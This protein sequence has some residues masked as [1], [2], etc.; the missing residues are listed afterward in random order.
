M[1]SFIPMLFRQRSDTDVSFP[2]V[3]CF[4][5]PQKKS[6]TCLVSAEES[7]FYSVVSVCWGER[8]CVEE[9]GFGSV[10]QQRATGPPSEHPRGA[11]ANWELPRRTLGTTRGGR[12]RAG[13]PAGTSLRRRIFALRGHHPVAAVGPG[14]AIG[15]GEG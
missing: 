13:A 4:K 15:A 14:R 11:T 5:P 9:P 2:I 3:K 10:M 12:G 6:F 7:W 1:D 8:V